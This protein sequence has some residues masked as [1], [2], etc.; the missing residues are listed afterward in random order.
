MLS[1]IVLEV[2]I[3]PTCDLLPF[4][5]FIRVRGYSSIYENYNDSHEQL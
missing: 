2:G 3:E 1:Q 4:L 5:H